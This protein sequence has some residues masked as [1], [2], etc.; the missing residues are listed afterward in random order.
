M[1]RCPGSALQDIGND[2]LGILSDLNVREPAILLASSDDATI[3]KCMKFARAWGYG[4]I[5]VV[6]LFA[7]RAFTS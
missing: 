2:V 1:P 7:W 5:L 4:G 3:R 6:N